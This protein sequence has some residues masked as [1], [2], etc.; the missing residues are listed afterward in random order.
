MF[1]GYILFEYSMVDLGL[2]NVFDSVKLF[3]Y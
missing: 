1:N 3:I 2:I